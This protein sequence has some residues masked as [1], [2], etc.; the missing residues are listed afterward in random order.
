MYQK[1]RDYMK[2]DST[3]KYCQWIRI[4][5]FAILTVYVYQKMGKGYAVIC[6]LELMIVSAAA[7]Q[8]KQDRCRYIVHSVGVL[9]IGIQMFLLIFGRTYLTLVMVTNLASI[10]DISGNATAYVVS[11]VLLCIVSFLPV[12]EVRYRHVS[13]ASVISIILVA[14]LICTLFKG[15]TYSPIYAYADLISQQQ[16]QKR[17]EKTVAEMGDVAGEFYKPEITNY[18]AKPESLPEKPNVIVIFTEGLSQNIVEDEREIMPNV[19]AYEEKSLNFTGYYNHTFATYRGLIGQLYS[20]YQMNN[21]DSNQLVS[22]QDIFKAEGYSTTFINVEP[23]NAPFTAYLDKMKFD[24]LEGEIGE[25]KNGMADSI[26]DKDAY[27]KLY[28]VMEERQNSGQPFM[29]SMYTFGTHATLDSTDQVYG[30]GKTAELNKF[31]DVDYQFGK[32]MEKFEAS[33]FADNTILIF[34]ADHCTYLDDEF[35]K[36]FPSYERTFSEADRIPFFIYYKGIE[37]QTVEAAGRNSL[38]FAPTVC[39]YLDIS[40]ENYFLGTSLFA[41]VENNSNYDTV[42]QEGQTY[43]ST[44]GNTVTELSETEKNI[45]VN[46]ILKYFS[47]CQAR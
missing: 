7:K 27:E 17:M 30:D 29:I 28:S 40:A 6:V 5:F 25:A 32:F 2:K 24:Y 41:N 14:E 18:Y 16:E 4:L 38:D 44:R 8:I 12:R 47:V 26:S 42:F 37:P 36:A 43:M 19:A 3:K 20:G 9:L 22:L 13:G 45:L 11:A 15:N 1:V 35:Y 10:E 33:E 34:T 39:D 31:Y 21:Y 46:G 23:N